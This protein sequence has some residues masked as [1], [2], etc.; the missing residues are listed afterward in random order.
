MFNRDKLLEETRKV[1]A[2]LDRELFPEAFEQLLN[3]MTSDD[4]PFVIASNLM[5]CDKPREFP[6]FLVAYITSLYEMEIAA[7]NAHAM[8]D[9]G[10]R[11]YSGNRGFEQDFNKA[12]TLYNMAA[13]HGNRQAQENLGYCYYYGRDG[14]VDYEKAFHCF[15]LGAFDGWPI[16][17]YKIGD[18]YL[19][20]FYVKKNEREAYAVYNR[21]LE[22]VDSETRDVVSGPVHLR[23]GNLYLNGIGTEK[24]PQQALLHYSLAEILLL[25]MV[26][27]GDYMYKKSL[28]DAIDGQAK[29]RAILMEQLP[30]GEWTFD[31]KD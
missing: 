8:I 17:L 29:A 14:E 9:L 26:Q 30:G 22:L 12:M 28:R 7:G 19:N 31:D 1:F 20:G 24:D 10:A 5:E 27:D 15:A 18:M 4:R 16:S 3:V 23:L 6:P 25:R 2:L 11:H 13:E 21:C